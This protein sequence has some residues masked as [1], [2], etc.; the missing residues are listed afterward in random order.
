MRVSKRAKAEVVIP[1]G[2]AALLASLMVAPVPASAQ[3]RHA[4]MTAPD[5]P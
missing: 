3:P 4:T 5:G 1:M 2:A